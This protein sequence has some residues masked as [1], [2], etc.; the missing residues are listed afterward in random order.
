[1]RPK[2]KLVG[3]AGLAGVAAT[4]VIVTR[5]RRAHRDYDPA[6][7]RERLRSRLDGTLDDTTTPAGAP[8]GRRH[9][10]MPNHDAKSGPAR[11]VSVAR[12][13]ARRRTAARL[14][15]LRLPAA[16]L[17]AVTIALATLAPARALATPLDVASD[18]VA[19]GAYEH[20][21]VSITAGLPAAQARGRAFASAVTQRCA[22]V[23]GPLSALASSQ[24]SQPALVALGEEIRDDVAVRFDGQARAA[25]TRFS[26]AL[27]RLRWSSRST[28]RTIVA[29]IA[30]IHASLALRS[31]ALCADAQTFASAPLLVP[32][33][34]SRFLAAYQ[35]A[36]S[37]ARARL[38]AFLKVL[39]RFQ[40]TSE[41][42]VIGAVDRLVT[43]YER[44]SSTDQ[45]ATSATIVNVLRARAPS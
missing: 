6:E 38:T 4:G 27:Q 9:H 25:F 13:P 11:M 19:L 28:A 39:E 34:T 21:L 37:A 14:G 7:L 31:S 20:Y 44:A 16:A 26:S 30:S 22:G 24:V 36:A 35:P 43:R 12:L 42:A 23:L 17:L 29:L 18:R 8:P 1:M 10:P 15:A 45:S 5:Q 3:L 32:A 2:W 33:G 40:T 41:A